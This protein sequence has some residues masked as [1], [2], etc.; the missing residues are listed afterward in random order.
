MSD[1]MRPTFL[2]AAFDETAIAEDH[3][4][5]DV[6]ADIAPPE[7]NVTADHA[8]AVVEALSRALA[9]EPDAISI[10]QGYDQA[11]SAVTLS[12]ACAPDD[13][14]RLIGRRGRVIQAVRQLARA[15]GSKDGTRIMVDVAE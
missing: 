14:G 4:E 11:R 6:E 3:H 12:I 9:E 1:D 13:T 7:V 10:S 5:D 8:A 2:A 15:A